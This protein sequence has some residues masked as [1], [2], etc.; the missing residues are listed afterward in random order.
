MKRAYYREGVIGVMALLIAGC[1]TS[2]DQLGNIYPECCRGEMVCDAETC[3][4]AGKTVRYVVIPSSK[5]PTDKFGRPYWG[6][7]NYETKLISISSVAPLRSD[8]LR[9]EMTH[10]VAGRWHPE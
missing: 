2:R 9:H 5:M 8:V 3:T 6:W 1:V 7:Y 4:L 10:A